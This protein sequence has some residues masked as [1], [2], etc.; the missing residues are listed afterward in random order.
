M[1]GKCEWC[2]FPA[3]DHLE[4]VIEGLGR[5][6]VCSDCLSNYVV[7]NYDY[8]MAKMKQVGMHLHGKK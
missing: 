8:I 4:I 3:D 2:K 1:M 6:L 5:W 7:H